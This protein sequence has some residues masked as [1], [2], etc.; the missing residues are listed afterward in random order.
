VGRFSQ[1]WYLAV[2]S[3]LVPFALLAV[4]SK[5]VPFA[6][7]AVTEQALWC[8]ASFYS[9]SLSAST[10]TAETRSEDET[11]P[12]RGMSS[13]LSSSSERRS[14]LYHLQSVVVIRDVVIRDH[15]PPHDDVK[16]W[17]LTANNCYQNC[18][19]V[20]A[21]SGIRKESTTYN[22]LPCLLNVREPGNTWAI[23]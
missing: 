12:R 20:P 2:A 23:L 22:E 15:C 17:L 10:S 5:L 14:S 16:C 19:P 3:K 9:H 11:T 6:L 1:Q 4:A 21:A 13:S 18:Q 7:L 8:A